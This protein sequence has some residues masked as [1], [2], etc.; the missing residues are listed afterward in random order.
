MD[1]ETIKTNP[2]VNAGT[3]TFPTTATLAST[4]N[5]T[6]GTVT[7]A[8]NVTTVNGLAANVITAAATATDFG[9]EI[10]TAIWTDTTAGDFT[11][12]ASVGKSVMNG[13]ALGTG[14]T[15]NAYTGDTPQTGDSYAR[16]GATGSGLTSLASQA[17]VNTIDDFLDTEVAAILEDTGTT[18]PAQISALNNLSAAQVNTEVDTALV[19]IGLDHLL[20][21]TVTGTDVVDNSIVARLVSKSATADWDTYAQTTDSLEALRDRG[22]A[23]WITATG[24][25]TL[26]AAGVRTAVGLASAN[27][28][29]QIGTLATA[30]ALTIVDDFLDTEIAAIKAKT[31]NLPSDP[32]DA[33]DIAALIDAVP[34]AAENAAGL[35]DLASGVETG[36]TPRQ[37]LRLITAASAGKLSGA[38]TTTVTIRN[39]VADSKDRV[40]ATVDADGNRSAITVDLT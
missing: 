32:A 17:S 4:T 25:S 30:A 33:S 35:L 16:I 19:D 7:T 20:S 31:D 24:F 36:L 34:N 37:A 10:A 6:A 2:V 18:I 14:L 21:A 28:D 12:A 5:I 26:D 9:A 13:V 40:V 23:A 27:L 39:A 29:T 15:I 3:I 8:T 1:I 22:D 11:V 38:A